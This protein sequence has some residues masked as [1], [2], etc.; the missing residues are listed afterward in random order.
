MTTTLVLIT[1][2]KGVAMESNYGGIAMVLL[3]LQGKISAII[4]DVFDQ[5]KR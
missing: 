1:T 5:K 4:T 2:A 3:P